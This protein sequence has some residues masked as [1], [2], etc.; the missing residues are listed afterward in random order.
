MTKLPL[1]EIFPLVRIRN[2]YG[3]K[4]KNRHFVQRKVT[5]IKFHMYVYVC[6]GLQCDAAECEIAQ[7]SW[8]LHLKS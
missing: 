2:N 3:S 1:L 4:S 6:T 7:K 8:V 5:I